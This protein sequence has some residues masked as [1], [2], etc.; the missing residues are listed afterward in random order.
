MGVVSCLLD[1]TPEIRLGNSGNRLSSTLE[2]EG[3]ELESMTDLSIVGSI[4]EIAFWML[5]NL[6]PSDKWP[7][8][9]ETDG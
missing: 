9:E 3:K 4:L 6:T 7:Q 5:E 8:D 1:L 2:V